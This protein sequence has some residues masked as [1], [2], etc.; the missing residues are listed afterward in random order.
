[1][2]RLTVF[3]A[4]VDQGGFSAAGDVLQMTTPEVMEALRELEGEVGATLL[5]R[6]GRTVGLTFAGESFLPTAR[7]ALRDE[8]NPDLDGD[9]RGEPI[10]GRLDLACL[11]TLVVAPVAPL[12]GQFRVLHSSVTIVLADPQDTAELLEF[13]TSGRSELGISS[14]VTV[15]GL[16]VIPLGDQEFC[17]VLPPGTNVRDP[18]PVAQL[19]EMPLVAAPK[20]SS[21]R[22]H[23]DGVFNELGVEANIVVE[24]APRDAFVPLIVAGAGSALLP[25]PL[26]EAARQLGCVVVD[27]L[28]AVRRPVSLVHRPG[29]LT[30]AAQLFISYVQSTR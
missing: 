19:A 14:A 21:T 16:A 11:P 1:M 10:V 18:L 24:T 12:V 23:L 29:H 6:V 7:L 3:L 27:P 26:G 15:E 25:R 28:P 8:A 4:V 22:S 9:T 5:N 20:G 30:P 13:V 17:V 2:S